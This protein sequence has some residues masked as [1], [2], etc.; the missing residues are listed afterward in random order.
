LV[1]WC[2]P[3]AK[4]AVVR[5]SND[6]ERLVGRRDDATLIALPLSDAQ[7]SSINVL[8]V[9]DED[10]ILESTVNVL[11]HNGYQVRSA[12]R[13]TDA[14]AILRE[15]TVD[16]ALIDLYMS[17]VSG[18]ELLSHC[19]QGAPRRGGHPD[20]GQAVGGVEHRGL[21]KGAW[22][23]LPK[24]FSAPQLAHPDRPRRAHRHR[25]ARVARARRPRRA[26][27]RRRRAHAARRVGR[28]F[29]EV[30]ALA[31][32]V[33]PTDA[34]VFITGESGTGKEMVAQFIHQMSRR[35]SREDGGPQLR[36]P[37]RTAPGV[38]DVR[39]REGRLHRRDAGQGG[40]HGGANGGTLFL[41]ELTELSP[42]TQAKLLRVVQDG[43][44]RRVGRPRPT[45]SSTSASSRRRTGIRRRPSKTERLREDL[46]YSLGVVPIH[47]PPL[48][49]RPEDIR[50]WRSTSSTSTGLA[51]AARGPRP[52]SPRTRP[53]LKQR[54]WKGNVRELQNV[55]EHA[56]VLA[57]VVT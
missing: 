10:T 3:I 23:Y 32:K 53:E 40:A 41:D 55:M 47:I 31:R 30:V 52:S 8:V 39:A 43:V 11:E 34:S 20:H 44:V 14:E 25:R 18:L 12:N 33:A 38:G 57:E 51:T 7:K 9:D 2:L 27:R 35:K 42:M 17:G 56:I 24:P 15:G 1:R 28:V 46:Y 29:R 36:G 49:Q 6:S 48:R 37:A 19:T 26:G 4:E 45:R 22:D 50:C 21:R 54:P 5:H 16:V 13:G